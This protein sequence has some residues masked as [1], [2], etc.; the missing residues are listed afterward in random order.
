M[1]K[2]IKQVIGTVN[3]IHCCPHLH[4][5]GHTECHMPYAQNWA[6]RNTREEY[7]YRLLIHSIN[8]YFVPEALRHIGR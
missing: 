2:N 6:G 4:S 1:A 7:C 5:S 8:S 3:N